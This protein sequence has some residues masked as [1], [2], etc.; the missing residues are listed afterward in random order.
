MTDTTGLS[1]LAP[2][3]EFQ[4]FIQ[5]YYLLEGA[6]HTVG[7]PGLS[8]DLWWLQG[9]TVSTVQAGFG[10]RRCGG[11]LIGGTLTRMLSVSRRAATDGFGVSLAP[12]VAPALFGIDAS[13]ITDAFVDLDY[14]L[15]RRL[16]HLSEQIFEAKSAPEK[17]R[18]FEH[19]LLKLLHK[20]DAID[21]RVQHVIGRLN[22]SLQ[23]ASVDKLAREIGYSRRRLVDLVQRSLGVSPKHLIQILRFRKALKLMERWSEPDWPSV[24][25]ECGYVDQAHF[26]H[27][28][29][30]FTGLSPR[31]YL[32]QRLFPPLLHQVPQA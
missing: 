15:K 17:I 16:P 21:D 11:A 30:Q 3:T 20:Q 4:P 32:A 25:H 18:V 31:Q 7:G 22:G 29:R 13:E 6:A 2:R 1:K 28:C 9:Q 24:V 12:V 27:H 23:D 8:M 26:I 14:L 5:A 10:E 19:E